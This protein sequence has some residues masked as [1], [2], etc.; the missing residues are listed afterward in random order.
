MRDSGEGCW[1]W[2]YAIKK[3]DELFPNAE[4]LLDD[5]P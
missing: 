2:N 5:A 1:R 3:V 4:L